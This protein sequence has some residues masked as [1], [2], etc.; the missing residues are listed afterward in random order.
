MLILDRWLS[1]KRGLGG[2]YKMLARAKKWA[3]GKFGKAQ[4]RASLKKVGFDSTHW[5]RIVAYRECERL[6]SHVDRKTAKVFE[7][8]PGEH[9]REYGFAN[10]DFAFFP[11]FDVCKGPTEKKYDLVIA[12]QVFEHVAYPWHATRNVYDMLEPGGTF[13]IVVP[14]MLKV[15][16]YPVDCTR[17]TDIGL[18]HML[19]DAGFDAS[20]IQTG[21]WGNKRAAVANLRNGWPMYGWGRTL[22]NDPR[23]PVMTWA[24]ARKP[25]AA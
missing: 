7:V 25:E 9:W 18:K 4:L 12:D 21:M 20:R 23:F 2:E 5:V 6:I 13:L 10:Y 19:V 14:F 22:H 1:I 3:L 8:S 16:G 24:I 15:H 11:E 17:W